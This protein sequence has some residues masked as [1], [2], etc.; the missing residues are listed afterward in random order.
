MKNIFISAVTRLG[1]DQVGVILFA[2]MLGLGTLALLRDSVLAQLGT[3]LAGMMGF[4]LRKLR[5]Y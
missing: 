3:L 2:A 1:Y 4:Q 5:S